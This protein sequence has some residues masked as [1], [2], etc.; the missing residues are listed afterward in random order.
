M[1]LTEYIALLD[2]KRI[3]LGK[4]IGN[5]ESQIRLIRQQK[6]VGIK[7]LLRAR[8]Q[9]LDELAELAELAE[10]VQR[11]AAGLC[12]NDCAEVQAIRRQIQQAEQQLLAASSL[13]VQLALNEKKRIADQMRG[14]SQAREIHQTYIGRWYQGVSRGFSR[15]V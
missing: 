6:M 2:E 1:I 11:E 3:L 15:K 7:R 13:A 14:N 10:L 5:T 12:W 9:L 8:R 4:I